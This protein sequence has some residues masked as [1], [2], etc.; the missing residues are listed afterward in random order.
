MSLEIKILDIGDIELDSSFL[1]LARDPG[2]L[3]RVPT[4]SYL[5]MGGSHLIL[6]DTGYRNPEIM[7]RLGMRGIQT[8][9]QVL[10]NALEKH[11]VKLGDIRYILHT[12]LHIDH[13]GKD[14]LFPKTTTVAI[15]RRELEYAVSGIMGGQYPPEDIKHLIDRLHMP[16]ALRLLDLEL[17][18]GEEIIP[19]VVCVAAGAHTEGSMNV[20]VE[21]S[22][23][24]ACICGD[25]VYD[26]YDQLVEPLFQVND[27][28]PATTGN[29][30][31]SKRAEKAAIKKALNASSFLLPM[32]DRPAVI[33]RGRVIGRLHDTVPGPMLPIK[34]EKRN[35]F[36]A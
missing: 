35:W 21:T 7:E 29:H 18:G 8:R 24:T 16:G 14:D 15:N 6:V 34:N 32:H 9:E 5:I 13:A 17:S 20:L 12:H 26:V 3:A 1:V 30:G 25:V 36:P 2:R 28:E 19:G 27:M 33:D 23:G 4:L 11:G 10:E 31:M 22:Q